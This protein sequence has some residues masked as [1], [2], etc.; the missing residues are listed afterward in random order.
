M[1]EFVIMVEIVSRTNGLGTTY[2]MTYKLIYW[3]IYW[4]CIIDNGLDIDLIYG[5]NI[6]VCIADFTI[7][8][9]PI[10]PNSF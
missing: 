2:R 8:E 3:L 10:I 4:L 7:S 5:I 1:L 9:W 6:W